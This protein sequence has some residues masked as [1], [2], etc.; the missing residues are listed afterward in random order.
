MNHKMLSKM[1]LILY[2]HLKIFL[3]HFLKIL[4]ILI[5]ILL[6]MFFD[7]TLIH[8]VSKTTDITDKYTIGGIIAVLL[9]QQ[10]QQRI[11]QQII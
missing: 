10:I 1:K 11:Y 4:I 6:I 8:M 9:F 3:L 7:I 5:L 2:V